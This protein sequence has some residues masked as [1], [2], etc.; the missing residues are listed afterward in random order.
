MAQ[1][2]SGLDKPQLKDD[3]KDI[4][5]YLSQQEDNQAD[6]IEYFSTKLSDAIE[7]YVKSGK[8]ETIGG[9]NAQTGLIV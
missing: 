3:I 1:P 8:V 4:L 5:E 9:P 6:G 2:G 7:K